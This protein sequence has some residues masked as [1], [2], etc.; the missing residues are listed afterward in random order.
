MF[1]TS[2][3]SFTGDFKEKLL[4]EVMQNCN[5]LFYTLLDD[6]KVLGSVLHTNYKFN[7]NKLIPNYSLNINY[8]T[9]SMKGV[10]DRKI[11]E[12]EKLLELFGVDNV[13]N[14]ETLI[15]SIKVKDDINQTELVNK[16]N[17]FNTEGAL[18]E[19]LKVIIDNKELNNYTKQIG[20]EKLLLE[21]DL[22]WFTNEMK[23]SLEA[24]SVILHDIYKSFNTNIIYVTIPYIKNNWLKFKVLVNKCNLQDLNSG[25]T[26]NL[27]SLLII[28]ILGNDSVIST[29]FQNIIEL[30]SKSD[31]NLK[32][33]RTELLFSLAAR[34]I[35]FAIYKLNNTYLKFK[36]ND[37]NNPNNTTAKLNDI[38][39][40]NE[41]LNIISYDELNKALNDI[42]NSEM[43]KLEIGDTILTF[44]EKST[45]ILERKLET[46]NNNREIF[47]SINSDY[48]KK[49][50]LSVINVT[51]LPMLVNPNSPDETGK[52]LPY[53]NGEISHIYNTFDSIVKT[54]HSIR[55]KVENQQALN[56]TINYLNNTAFKINLDVLDFILTEWE[57][58]NSVY[59]NEFNKLQV[60]NK[61]DTEE[62]KRNKQSHNSKYWRY[63][64]IINIATL[65]KEQIFYLLTF[66]EFRGR[67]YTLSQYLTY[68]GDDLCR[69]LLLFAS[70]KP[71]HDQPLNR[72]GFNYLLFYFA[73]LYGNKNLSYHE[74][75]E[76]SINNV[77]N[78]YEMFKNNKDKFNKEVLPNIKEPFQFIGIMFALVNS[79]TGFY[80]NEKFVLNNPILFDATCNGLQQLSA[81][82]RE[83]EIATKPNLISQAVN[84]KNDLKSKF[85]L[86]VASMIQMEIDQ[87]DYNELNNLKI[88]RDL[89][90]KTVKTIPYNISGYGVK[91]QMREFFKEYRENNKLYFKVETV[92]SKQNKVLYLLPSDVNKLGTIIY[93][94][95]LSKIPSL[96]LLNEYLDSLLEILSVLDK[97]IIWITPSGLKISLSNIKY[98]SIRTSSSLLP[99]GK[100]VTI[101]IPT[102]KLNK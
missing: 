13:S 28:I 56:Q 2:I 8:D 20:I 87:N 90:K 6:M 53:I 51:Q 65:Y 57:K 66:A 37:I 80:N 1:S 22:N 44:I 61:T 92:N 96:R 42:K 19:Q 34:L 63:L 50:N 40:I 48:I 76:W 67:I 18:I 21:Y 39:R 35:K 97:P 62:V 89:V 46:H 84:N 86:Y 100:P 4:R 79:I 10:L 93:E 94:T 82:T 69:S 72:K 15:Q 95:I 73:N 47:L 11:S 60:V 17:R 74:R 12:R 52:Y 71:E 43:S 36:N 25:N 81:M 78:I 29:S 99:I 31:D 59:F 58:D 75:I 98:E 101:S 30:I 3:E 14:L 88:T 77:L 23:D 64:Y 38:K 45:K 102:N 55:D 26:L 83:L 49:L 68:Q 5:N 24:R 85:Y 16:L 27:T 41:V 32:V 33:N 54:K 91:E 70:T 7:I 9:P